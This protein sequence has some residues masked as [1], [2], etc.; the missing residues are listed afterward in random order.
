MTFQMEAP[1]ESPATN[2]RLPNPDLRDVEVF[3]ADVLVYK[4]RSNDFY[5]YARTNDDRELNFTWSMLSREKLAEVL[6]FM[7]SFAGQNIK[8]ITHDGEIWKVL[9][10]TSPVEIS[11]DKL[12]KPCGT[13]LQESGSITLE[14]IGKRIS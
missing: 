7:N 13:G 3:R 10:L 1:Y 8:L 11:L 14:F 4:S 5:S 9:L 2:M 12:T 6:E